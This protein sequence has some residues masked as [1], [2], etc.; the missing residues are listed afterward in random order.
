MELMLALTAAE[1]ATPRAV[2]ESL[3]EGVNPPRPE[4]GGRGGG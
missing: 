2:Q 4:G 1:E 3:V